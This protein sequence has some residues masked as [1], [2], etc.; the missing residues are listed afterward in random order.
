MLFKAEEQKEQN[1]RNFYGRLTMEAS[2]QTLKSER[3]LSDEILYFRNSWAKS[4]YMWPN[5]LI[6]IYGSSKLA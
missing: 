4:M 2:I 1:E 5:I 3:M 6:C